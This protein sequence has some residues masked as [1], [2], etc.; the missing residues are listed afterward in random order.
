MCNSF[1]FSEETWPK[2]ASQ[3]NFAIHETCFFYYG[4]FFFFSFLSIMQKVLDFSISSEYAC[5]QGTQNDL[6]NEKTS[7]P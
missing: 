1:P 3:D 6:S 4:S 5:P 2:L 7:K